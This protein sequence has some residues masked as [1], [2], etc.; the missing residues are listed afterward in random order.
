MKKFYKNIIK[1]GNQPSPHERIKEISREIINHAD[2]MPKT[3]SYEDIDRAF[4]GWVDSEIKITQ[5]G[6]LLPTMVLYSNQRFSE[7]MQTW[8]YTDENNNVRLNFKTVTRDN[9]PSQGSIVGA[10]KNIPGER[11]YTFHK[12]DAI[13]EAGKRFRIDYKMRQPTPIDISYKVSVMTNRYATINSFNE[14]INRMFNAKQCYICPNGHY[15][16]INLENINDESEYNIEDRQFFSQS[17]KVVVK[18][19]IVTEDD[20]IVEENPVSTILCF[21]GDN[22]KRRRP[23]IEL[24]EYNTCYNIDDMYYKK[25]IDI[26]V[27]LSFCPPYQG[28]IKFTIDEDFILT[29]FIPKKPNS[30]SEEM[31]TLYVNDELITHD[32]VGDAYEGYRKCEIIPHEALNVD[33]AVYSEIPT[34]KD[35]TCKYIKIGDDFYEWHRIVFCDGDEIKINVNRKNVFTNYAG[36][37]LNGY[38]KFDVLEKTV[39]E[40]VENITTNQPLDVKNEK[41]N[42]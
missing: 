26:D 37:V 17:I 22:A 39:G 29:R 2:Y 13:D 36:F 21:E 33:V 16:S 38:N 5:D 28:K 15:M 11:F 40:D 32:L 34:K 25:Q 7:Y 27:D 41:D 30:V 4:K 24:C 31:I 18:G 35:K 12:I 19:Y 6:T 3:L 20:L 1:L 23:T 10:G 8:K 42:E 9:N 14:T